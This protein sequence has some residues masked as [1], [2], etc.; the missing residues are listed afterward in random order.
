MTAK[1]KQR[2]ARRPRRWLKR[3]LVVL[4][5]VVLLVVALVGLAPRLVPSFF[6]ARMDLETGGVL[7]ATGW[8]LRWF[9]GQQIEQIRLWDEQ[10]VQ[11]AD[12]SLDMPV[13]LADIVMGQRRIEP[14]RLTGKIDVERRADGSLNLKSVVGTG[15]GDPAGT[16]GAGTPPT[17]TGSREPAAIQL[18]KAWA[19]TLDLSGLVLSYRDVK[20]PDLGTQTVTL[21]KGVAS[22]SPSAGVTLDF[23]A[24]LAS[25]GSLTIAGATTTFADANRIIDPQTVV[26]ELAVAAT[27]VPIGLIDSLAG[28]NGLLLGLVGDL[29]QLN[30]DVSGGMS[31]ATAVGAIRSP[32]VTGDLNL[33]WSDGVL[34]AEEGAQLLTLETTISEALL[35]SLAP[36]QPLRLS[37]I[38]PK[39]GVTIGE[40]AVPFVLG[41]PLDLRTARASVVVDLGPTELTTGTDLVER[42]AISGLRAEVSTTSLAEGLHLTA[43]GSVA[44]DGAEEGIIDIDLALTNLL[45][46]QGGL[47]PKSAMAQGEAALKQL[48]TSILQ[49]LLAGLGLETVRDIGPTLDV[50]LTA[51]RAMSAGT[52]TET[53]LGLRLQAEKVQAEAAAVL[54]GTELRSAGAT[55]LHLEIPGAMLQSYLPAEQGWQVAQA[56]TLDVSL[57]SFVLPMD[58]AKAAEA[59]QANAVVTLAGQR[60]TQA[61]GPT[62]ALPQLRLSLGQTEQ[63]KQQRLQLGGTLEVDGAAG[64]IAGD[65][66]LSD[67]AAALTG[68]AAWQDRVLKLMPTGEITLSGVDVRPF[69]AGLPEGLPVDDL[70]GGP[71]T[72]ALRTQPAEATLALETTLSTQTLRGS[73][74]AALSSN[75]IATQAVTLNTSV[76]PEALAAIIKAYVPEPAVDETE[77]AAGAEAAAKWSPRQLVFLDPVPVELT[78]RPWW[79]SLV[80]SEAEVAP[81]SATLIT[82]SSF[83]VSGLPMEMEPVSLARVRADAEVDLAG[84]KPAPNVKLAAALDRPASGERLVFVEATLAA[85][86]GAAASVDLVAKGIDVAQWE[87]LLKRPAGSLV[88]LLGPAGEVTASLAGTKTGQQVHANLNLRRLQGDVKGTLAANVF[89]LAEPAELSVVIAPEVLTNTLAMFLTDRKKQPGEGETPPPHRRWRLIGPRRRRSRCERSR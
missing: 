28:S 49:P 3:I 8:K 18:P 12:L 32:G 59:L 38:A 54:T 77:T 41:E 56:G 4:V 62:L 81:L 5:V 1:A 65:I 88:G 48:P 82:P 15:G 34:R 29:L 31:G 61:E 73:A 22:Y 84:E 47:S 26:M 55:G 20:Q 30:L 70:L 24:G 86:T 71:L 13:H 17:G 60:L 11:V 2:T 40:V 85:P 63:A 21:T 42:L 14:I 89:E 35:A 51:E 76:S 72:L 27:D 46:A 57:D 52:A 16:G 19:A 58:F 74:S 75:A 53:K 68:D 10:G 43:Q 39:L 80:E 50:A 36:D 78:M 79:R 25:G 87:G 45:D 23:A 37:G 64:T 33:D 69:L 9:D 7:Q 67:P 83:R 66:R 44:A 6:T